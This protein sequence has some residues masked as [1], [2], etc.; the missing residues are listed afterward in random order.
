MPLYKTNYTLLRLFK[1]NFPL[2]KLYIA[3]GYYCV[4]N[5]KNGPVKQIVSALTIKFQNNN[6]RAIL[7]CKVSSVGNNY[8]K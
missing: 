3:N 1:S 6:D 5:I 8:A 2:T 4:K 7:I